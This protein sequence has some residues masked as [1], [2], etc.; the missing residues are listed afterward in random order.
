MKPLRLWITLILVTP[1]FVGCANEIGDSCSTNI[2]C[3]PLGGR[4]CDTSQLEGYCTVAGC[5]IGTCPEEAVC[6]RFFPTAF[7]SVPCN[8]LTEDA[9]Q[10]TRSNDCTD[11]PEGEFCLTGGYCVQKT[12]GTSFCMKT[13]EADDDCRDGYE[14]RS[15]GTQGAE[16]VPDPDNP[17]IRPALFCAPRI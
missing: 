5:D 13:C 17:G 8:P 6:V 3:D 7:L 9:V 4:I 1:L 11:G 12:Q 16:A 15:T 14:C 10:G 2:D